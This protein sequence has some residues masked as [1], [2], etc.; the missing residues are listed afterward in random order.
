MANSLRAT[1]TTM[2]SRQ[3]CLA[4]DACT[5][6]ASQLYFIVAAPLNKHPNGEPSGPTRVADVEHCRYTLSRAR[7]RIPTHVLGEDEALYLD[8]AILPKCTYTSR[9]RVAQRTFSA[10]KSFC[11]VLLLWHCHFYF[12][13]TV[14]GRGARARLVLAAGWLPIITSADLH[15]SFDNPT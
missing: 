6:N 3:D 7:I 8:L 1:T 9:M 11:S 4:H 12:G 13:G 5:R 10:S 14:M 15:V 2:T